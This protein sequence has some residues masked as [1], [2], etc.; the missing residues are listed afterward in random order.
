MSQENVEIAHRAYKAFSSSD[1]VGFVA[2][3]DP[4]V[5]FESLLLEAEGATYRGHEGVR[6]YFD[7][8]HD[9]FPDW[10]TEIT[11]IRDFGDVLVIESRAAGTGRGSTV[12]LGQRFWQAARVKNGKI[13]WWKFVRTEDEALEAVGLLE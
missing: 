9:V 3:M 13:V 2:L 10:Q 1:W 8:V 4:D 6:K 11:A 5:E 12:A 7:A